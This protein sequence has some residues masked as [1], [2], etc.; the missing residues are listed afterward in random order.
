MSAAN[1][2]SFLKTTALFHI[3][4]IFFYLL[5]LIVFSRFT[6]SILLLLVPLLIF[7]MVPLM[8]RGL[9]AHRKKSAQKEFFPAVGFLTLFVLAKVTMLVSLHENLSALYIVDMES[10]VINILLVG[11]FTLA[12]ALSIYFFFTTDSWTGRFAFVILGVYSAARVLNPFGIMPEATGWI[13][14]YL[15][16]IALPVLLGA[17]L[18]GAKRAGRTD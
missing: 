10:S 6:I 2:R 16:L 5:M 14:Q 17:M 3:Y 4:F 12:L 11:I 13:L 9:E 8:E 1:Q 18:I 7:G 15:T